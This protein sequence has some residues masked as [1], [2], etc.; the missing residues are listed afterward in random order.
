M[1]RLVVGSGMATRSKTSK[2]E[3]KDRRSAKER[4]EEQLREYVQDMIDHLV[5]SAAA[6]DVMGGISAERVHALQHDRPIVE[7]AAA[8]WKKARPSQALTTLVVDLAAELARHE[9]ALE[10]LVKRCEALVHEDSVIIDAADQDR[11]AIEAA[12]RV[13]HDHDHG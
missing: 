4:E 13:D 2:A 5:D 1:G 11:E 10:A 6:A 7:A 3:K 12:I 9:D 8:M